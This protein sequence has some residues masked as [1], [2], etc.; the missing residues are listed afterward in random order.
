MQDLLAQ[1]TAANVNHLV[2]IFVRRKRVAKKIKSWWRHQMETFSALLV[3][4]EV[5]SPVTG[6]LPSQRPVTRSY[7]VFFALRLNKRLSKQSIRL[8]FEMPSSPLGRNC[9]VPSC[10]FHRAYIVSVF[11][12]S[13]WIFV[14]NPDFQIYIKIPVMLWYQYSD[15]ILFWDCMF[16]KPFYIQTQLYIKHWNRVNDYSSRAPIPS[17]SG[18]ASH[19]IWQLPRLPS[20]VINLL[21]TLS[22]T[23]ANPIFRLRHIESQQVLQWI[24]GDTDHCLSPPM[25]YQC[26]KMNEVIL[27]WIL[28]Q[29]QHMKGFRQFR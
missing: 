13:Q 15:L 21:C 6:E 8:W 5:N 1:F 9:N 17:I 16:H 23:L 27:L 22:C 18:D 28:R 24:V 29:I 26:W 19:S 3:L 25:S 2:Y 20:Q 14:T 4:C 7:D 11:F 12:V 10:N